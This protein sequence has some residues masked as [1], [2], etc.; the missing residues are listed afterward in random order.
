MALCTPS[1]AMSF[2]SST[3][4]I[5]DETVDRFPG[6]CGLAEQGRDNDPSPPSYCLPEFDPGDHRELWPEFRTE[7]LDHLHQI[8]SSLLA[9]DVE[10]QNRDALDQLFR[11]F[12][13]L[14]GMSGFLRLGPMHA[15]T[16]EVES[17]LELARSGRLDLDPP[18]ITVILDS[19][20]A[21]QAMVAQVAGALERGVH[22][23]EGIPVDRLIA[24]VKLLVDASPGRSSNE[25][26]AAAPGTS[27]GKNKTAA[28]AGTIRVGTEKLDAIMNVADE[29]VMTHSQIV[30]SACA[31][32]DANPLLSRNI[33]QLGRIVKELQCSALS[34][35]LMSLQPVFQR[36]ERLVRDLARHCGKQ[37]QFRSVG[38]GTEIDRTLV[39]GI[40][41]P[42]VH[43]IRNALDHGIE[44]PEARRVAGKPECGTVVLK[45]FHQGS[46]VHIELGDDGQGID[47][48]RVHAR[49]LEMGLVADGAALTREETIN[50]I[51]HPGFST[52]D[53][54]TTVSGRGVGMDV[55]RRNIERLHGKIEVE[56]RAGHGTTFRI[57]LPLTL[58]VIGGH[59][60]VIPLSPTYDHDR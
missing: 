42:L 22:D 30:E 7:A 11:S 36:M 52:A 43:M 34:L 33:A 23:D 5:N 31:L 24:R 4:A 15:L 9:L 20:D 16:H 44:A 35:R 57:T 19:R 6:K 2:P 37:C 39:E 53:R 50:L 56:T 10:P 54:V 49:A 27:S 60:S 46:N 13:T 48:R 59:R 12:H 3:F 8:E 25:R 1:Q 32:T 14:K 41:D 51:F 58:I 21:V 55:V 45:L 40:A 29:L 17:L 28:M 26:T 18:V 38:E 47:P